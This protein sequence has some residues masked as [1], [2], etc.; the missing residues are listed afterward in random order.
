MKNPSRTKPSMEPRELGPIRV[1]LT[2]KMKPAIS[3]LM[4]ILFL[5]G[6]AT[7][8]LRESEEGVTILTDPKAKETGIFVKVNSNVTATGDGIGEVNILFVNLMEEEVFLE[9]TGFDSLGWEL[10]TGPEGSGGVE[11]V[12]PDNINHLKRLHGSTRSKDGNLLSCG[13]S[14]VN[15]KGK[16]ELE[17]V[18]LEEWVGEKATVTIPV[19]G[20]IR[21]NGQ[22]FHEWVELPIK[23]VHGQP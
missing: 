15:V 16:L 19:N 18:N 8:S 10:N 11:W 5:T 9:I 7:S 6:C 23:I 2:V 1:T 17:G 13:C 22:K 14:M 4:A 21:K 12:F 20:Y 3:Y